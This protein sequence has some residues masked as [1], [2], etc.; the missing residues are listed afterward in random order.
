MCKNVKIIFIAICVCVLSLVPPKED[1]FKLVTTAIVVVRGGASSSRL[2]FSGSSMHSF[3]RLIASSSPLI[4]V[5]N[6]KINEN[7]KRT[8]KKITLI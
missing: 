2:N 5:Q 3:Q 4:C 8:D 6:I 1:G 7:K